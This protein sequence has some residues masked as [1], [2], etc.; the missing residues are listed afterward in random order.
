MTPPPSSPSSSEEV[1]HRLPWALVIQIGGLLLAIVILSLSSQYPV[2]DWI[3]DA[4]KQIESLGLWSGIVYPIAYAICNVLLLPGGVLSIGGGFLFGLW[5]GFLIVLVGNLLGAAA[6]FCI[7]RRLGRR[8]IE[9]LMNNSRRLRLIDH[10]IE[11]H[12]WKIVVLSQLNPLAPSSL[13]NYLYGLTRV[14]LLRCLG[15]VALGQTPGLFLYVFIGT[16]GQFG[17]E[18]ARGTK[19]PGLHDYLAWGGGF[20]LTISTTYMLGRL[21]KRILA[22]VEAE[23]ESE[24]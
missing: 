2:L 1:S 16:L 18:M 8:R 10:A 7:A 23:L 22:E 5:W 20:I 4:R 21:A 9:K 12:G 13:L 11:R 14:P 15:W 6:A 3:G 19:Q 24:T 17:V